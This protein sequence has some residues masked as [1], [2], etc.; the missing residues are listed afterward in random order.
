MNQRSVVIWATLFVLGWGSAIFFGAWSAILNWVPVVEVMSVD[1]WRV[2]D[3]K[4]SF[5]LNIFKIR[6]CAIV[7]SDT[8]AYVRHDGHDW[9]RAQ[10]VVS[11]EP[12]R[13]YPAMSSHI[14]HWTISDIATPGHPTQV[15]MRFEH[16]CDNG[17]IQTDVGPFEVPGSGE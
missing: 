17:I 12:L 6:P 16:V 2:A 7:G 4:I 15:R 11:D 10:T 9:E 1:D 13:T 5:D 14:R 8:Q 3:G